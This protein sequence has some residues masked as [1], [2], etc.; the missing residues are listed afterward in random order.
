M[1]STFVVWLIGVMALAGI[2]P[3]SGFF[4]KDAVL[5]AV[6]HANTLAG[7][8][9]FASTALTGFYV[10]RTTRLVFF[11][12]RAEGLHA[13]ESPMTML[14][15]L[16]VLSVPA[17]AFGF[18]HAT[19][20]ELL[21]SEAEPFALVLSAV[22][23]L[24]VATGI[25]VG[26]TTS[27]GPA[28]DAATRR[29]LGA[30]GDVLASAFG[31]DRLVDRVVVRPVISGSRMLWALGDRFL[32][33]GAVETLAA[34]TRLFGRRLSGLQSGDAQSYAVAMTVA[35]AVLLA[36]ASWMGR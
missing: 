15:P 6:W 28:G 24:L 31:W 7:A 26:W 30:F 14:A 33:N 11:G 23:L 27:V 17:A 2:A 18:A 36:V 25:T 16:F 5:E 8:L 32:V 19:V 12:E 3:L 9:L 4:S 29:R 22:T 21:G 35:V 34:T 10:A 13:H 1:P 20:S